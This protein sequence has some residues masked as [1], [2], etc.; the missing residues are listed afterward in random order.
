MLGHLY[1]QPLQH[2]HTKQTI[3]AGGIYPCQ[4]HKRGAPATTPGDML[5]LLLLYVQH[6]TG[7]KSIDI[8]QVQ[9]THRLCVDLHRLYPQECKWTTYG[10][11]PLSMLYESSTKRTASPEDVTH[12]RQET[13]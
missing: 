5:L 3:S 6:K 7:D 1:I 4:T 8:K 13:N 9:H 12:K 11:P 2:A 10:R